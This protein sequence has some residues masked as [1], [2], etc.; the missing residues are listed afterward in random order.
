M[1]E[2]ANLAELREELYAPAC[3]VCPIPVSTLAKS[4]RTS[5]VDFGDKTPA[6]DPI[7][8]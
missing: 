8:E 5:A 6:M 4:D 2:S 7:V 1:A 3:H